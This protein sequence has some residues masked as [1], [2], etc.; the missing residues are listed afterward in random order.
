MSD[1]ISTHRVKRN[2]ELGR[3]S[4]EEFKA[5]SKLP[6]TIV[7][8]NVRSQHNIGSVFRTAD[9]FIM[10]RIILCGICATPPTAEI[11]KSAL[12]A[13]FSVDWEYFAETIDAV[14]KLKEEGY[15]IISIEQAENSISLEEAAEK[16]YGD[17][18]GSGKEEKKTALIF[19]NEVK[20]VNQSVVDASDYVIEI[21]QFGTKHSLNIS[22]SAGMVLWEFCKELLIKQKK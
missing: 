19:G 9:S 18:S 21:P 13:E 16:I 15:T 22:V 20:G 6:V 2:D 7:L 12:G 14:K 11:H 3:I 17:L 4:V 5:H 1:N 10:D 8:D